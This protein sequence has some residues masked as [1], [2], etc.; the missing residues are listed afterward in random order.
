MAVIPLT[1]AQEEILQ[2]SLER[3]ARNN[4]AKSQSPV[5]VDV[6]KVANEEV[7]SLEKSETNVKAESPAQD[8][9]LGTPDFSFSP[10][11]K[12]K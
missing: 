3:E 7:S 12:R 11:K 2:K 4:A 8:P 5:V 9:E 1:P 10:Y 6:K